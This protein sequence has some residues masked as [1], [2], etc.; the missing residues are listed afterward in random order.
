MFDLFDRFD[1]FDLF[2]EQMSKGQG[3]DGLQGQYT[4]RYERLKVVIQKKNLA[5]GDVYKLRTKG[6]HDR[7]GQKGPTLF[8]LHSFKYSRI[9]KICRAFYMC[10]GSSTSSRDFN[11][12][13]FS[14]FN[15]T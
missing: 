3:L 6:R 11:S 10:N 2:D 7:H 12:S 8:G 13:T 4:V 9:P 15:R 5:M 14:A 1:L